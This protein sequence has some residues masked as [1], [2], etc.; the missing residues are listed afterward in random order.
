MAEYIDR[1]AALMKL[2]Q[3][4]CS[5]K[6]CNPS[7]ICPPPMLRL[8]CTLIGLKRKNTVLALCTIV[9]CVT[10]AFLT[11]G[12]R[13]TTVPTA[14]QKWTKVRIKMKYFKDSTFIFEALVLMGTISAVYWIFRILAILMV[15]GLI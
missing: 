2:M 15:K 12:I 4:G 5:A 7:R 14:A 8:L 1:E 10:T 6:N 3:D 13:G 9:L 11:T